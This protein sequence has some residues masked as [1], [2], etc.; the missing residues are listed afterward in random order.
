MAPRSDMKAMQT[1]NSSEQDPGD[2]ARDDGRSNVWDELV[3]ERGG[4]GINHH[5]S[6]HTHVAHIA[7][8]TGSVADVYIATTL[9]DGVF[10]MPSVD[11]ADATAT[12]ADAATGILGSLFSA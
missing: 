7:D 6:R 4:S 10:G 11:D 1:T 2:I 12:A 8:I 9:I 3:A 5:A